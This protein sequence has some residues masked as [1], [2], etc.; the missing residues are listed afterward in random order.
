M[1]K[2]TLLAIG[3]FFSNSAS[4]D[5]H[6]NERVVSI[7]IKEGRPYVQFQTENM[8]E[9]VVWFNLNKSSEHYSDM[10]SLLL[11]AKMSGEKIEVWWDDNNNSPEEDVTALIKY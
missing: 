11:A 5:Q 1:K 2:I 10:Y 8:V 9:G 6:I 7:Y 4:A 3:L